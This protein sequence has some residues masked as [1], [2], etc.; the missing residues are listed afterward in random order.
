M[1]VCPCRGQNSSKCAQSGHSY[2][3]LAP[4]HCVKLHGTS[5]KLGNQ[6]RTGGPSEITLPNWIS[7]LDAH[8]LTVDARAAQLKPSDPRRGRLSKVPAELYS[9]CAPFR[10]LTYSFSAEN[11]RES[12]YILQLKLHKP[13]T[14]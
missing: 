13:V 6:S 2:Q 8:R 4:H 1:A 10:P 7:G 12:R 11:A 14:Y 9:A 5:G 3:V